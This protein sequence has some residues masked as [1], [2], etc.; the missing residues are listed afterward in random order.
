ML[1]L[2]NRIADFLAERR[3]LPT[4]IG[5]GLILINFVLQFFPGLGWLVESNL[6]LHLGALLSIGGI[7]L[8]NAL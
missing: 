2:L 7:L 6:L 8:A 1:N 5:M 4:L 3:G